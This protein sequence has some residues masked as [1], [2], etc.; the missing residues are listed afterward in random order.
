MDK[1][2]LYKIEYWPVGTDYI[3]ERPEI[4]VIEEKREKLRAVRAGIV[5]S[6]IPLHADHDMTGKLQY[7]INGGVVEVPRGLFPFRLK[8]DGLEEYPSIRL[9]HNSV[10]GIENITDRF[11]LA[12]D[13]N[14]VVQARDRVEDIIEWILC[15]GASECL[16]RATERIRMADW[17][18]NR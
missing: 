6:Y 16:E 8:I 4:G 3:K 11:N 18:K 9:F 14:A 10:E 1:V 5:L 12:F 13:K 7:L 15:D 2:N 17:K